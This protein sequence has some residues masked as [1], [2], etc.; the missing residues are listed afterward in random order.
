[1]QTC[2]RKPTTNIGSLVGTY[3]KL[4]IRRDGLAYKWSLMVH[5]EQIATGRA[6]THK[7]CREAARDH[8]AAIAGKERP[9]PYAARKKTGAKI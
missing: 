4:V 7:A 3:A 8:R 1:M 5:E 6:K 2:W 9:A